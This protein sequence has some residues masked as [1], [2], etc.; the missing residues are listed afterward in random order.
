MHCMP[1]KFQDHFHKL[2]IWP[3]FIK[4][5]TGPAGGT[6]L[7]LGCLANRHS[8][9]PC[10]FGH[11]YPIGVIC[12]ILPACITSKLYFYLFIVQFMTIS[13]SS[14]GK[15]CKQC[16]AVNNAPI[17]AKLLEDFGYHH[18]Y[19]LAEF[20]DHRPCASQGGLLDLEVG[21]APRRQTPLGTPSRGRHACP[22]RPCL[23]LCLCLPS[24]R[25]PTS[26]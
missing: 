10:V 3:L 22:W 23:F 20:R 6:P 9:N 5:H 26:G 15:T 16:R 2:K 19:T 7:L 13:C 11:N 24:R 1:C 14:C 18:S 8:I 4:S 12:H 25:S 17:D 21:W